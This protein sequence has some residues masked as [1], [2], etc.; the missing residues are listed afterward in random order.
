MIQLHRQWM[1]VTCAVLLLPGA[2]F[3]QEQVG[4]IAGRVIDRDTQQPIASAQ[5]VIVGTQVGAVTDDR[6]EFRITRVTPGSRQLRALRLGYQTATQTV[7][8]RA[9]ET[10]T[11]D[12]VL[13]T[14][15]VNLDQ[16]VI[17]ATGETQRKRESGA[18]TSTIAVDALDLAPITNLSQVLT[19]RAPGVAVQLTSGTLGSGTRIRIR[20]TS[21]ISLANEDRKSV[22]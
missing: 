8:V 15:A 12:F 7:A 3:A 11:A 5:V 22:V 18:I 20:G 4:A 10:A 13:G 2:L 16:V 1:K 19:G 9:G 6:G 14:A 17:T 21:S